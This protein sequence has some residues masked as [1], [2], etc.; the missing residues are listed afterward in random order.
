MLNMH[1]LFLEFQTSDV[2][3]SHIFQYLERNNSIVPIQNMTD[4]P[5]SKLASHL[6][7][8][9]HYVIA[10][11]Y[12]FIGAPQ[13]TVLQITIVPVVATQ[14]IAENSVNYTNINV[15]VRRNVPSNTTAT[16]KVA[17]CCVHQLL[18]DF[19]DNNFVVIIQVRA[20]LYRLDVVTQ[21]W[22]RCNVDFRFSYMYMLSN[23][24]I[25]H[26][27]ARAYY[28]RLQRVLFPD[29]FCL[30][31]IGNEIQQLRGKSRVPTIFSLIPQ[32]QFIS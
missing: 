8:F 23:N 25:P 30:P 16:Q 19:S 20:E 10:D 5:K 6:Q 22:R 3:P 14:F 9:H 2:C 29:F 13:T 27:T 11:Y 21:L 15:H 4:L 12:R 24:A 17:S 7:I 18:A 32:K 28:I 31:G 1:Q 26:T